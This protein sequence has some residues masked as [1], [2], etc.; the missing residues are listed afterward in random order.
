[1]T[2]GYAG[3]ILF[4]DLS[5]G[6]VQ[7]ELLDA[8]VARD[9]LGNYGLG[10]K[11]LYNRQKAGVDPLGPENIL[12]FVTG[13]LVGVWVPFGTRTV[14]VGKSPPGGRRDQNSLYPADFQPAR[15]ARSPRFPP[16]RS[17]HQASP[18]R[19]W[20]ARRNQ[21]GHEPSGPGVFPEHGTGPGGRPTDP[22]ASG[23]AGR[24]RGGDH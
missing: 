9:F 6:E 5:R 14:V 23:E 21:P 7:T 3:R 11:I 12:D 8:D 15:G 24:I 1:M 10:A 22:A 19:E 17:Y 2:Q 16:A 13:P 18:L 4:I 20:P